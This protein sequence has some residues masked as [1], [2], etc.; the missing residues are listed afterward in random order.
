MKGGELFFHIKTSGTFS[1]I[2][3]KFYAAEIL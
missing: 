1:P 3:T 2:V